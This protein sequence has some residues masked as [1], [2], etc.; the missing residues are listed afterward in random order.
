MDSSGRNNFHIIDLYGSKAWGAIRTQGEFAYVFGGNTD[1]S[2]GN[3]RSTNTFGL[4]LSGDWKISRFT[5]DLLFAFASGDNSPGNAKE[6]NFS[7]FSRN[8]RPT[9][10]LFTEY[11]GG[12]VPGGSFNSVKSG[13]AIGTFNS[14]GAIVMNVGEVVRISNRFFT[15]GDFTY[16]RLVTD[17]ISPSKNLGFEIDAHVGFDWYEN[18][19][20]RVEGGLLIAQDAFGPSPGNV[21]AFNL[22]GVLKF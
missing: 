22:N 5:T 20:T 8:I 14:D 10:I 15:G 19:T 9:L 4:L 11:L 13:P 1:P 6:E 17:G 2:T 7:F 3:S 21:W 12:A 16:A 18:F